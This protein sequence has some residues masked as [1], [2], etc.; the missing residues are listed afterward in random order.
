M[1]YE[2]LREAILSAELLPGCKLKVMELKQR[3]GLGQS[4]IREALN[5]LVGDGLVEDLGTRGFRVATVSS[6][7]LADL[8]TVLATVECWALAQ[9]IERGDAS[10]ESAILATLHTLHTVEK[11]PSKVRQVSVWAQANRDFHDALLSACGSNTLMQIRQ[12]LQAKWGR[13]A[14]LSYRMTEPDLS[15][16]SA[17]HEAIARAA[18]ARD[19]AQAQALVRQHILAFVPAMQHKIHMLSPEHTQA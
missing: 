8:A 3:L 5:R 15:D 2:M 14:A 19:T 9:S 7:N 17:E 1:S 13:Y 10:W 11:M 16:L 12:E 4:P 6:E 18:I